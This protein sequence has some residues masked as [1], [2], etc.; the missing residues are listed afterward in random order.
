MLC[1]QISRQLILGGSAEKTAAFCLVTVMYVQELLR[2]VSLRAARKQ[3]SD[4]EWSIY[5][6]C[7]IMAVKGNPPCVSGGSHPMR[8]ESLTLLDFTPRCELCRA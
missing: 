8:A 3:S 4:S 7:D 2:Y 6:L 5:S 1:W